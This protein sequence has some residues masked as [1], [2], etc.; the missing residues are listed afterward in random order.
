MKD[1]KIDMTKNKN[2]KGI[3]GVFHAVI[4]A[5]G[6]YAPECPDMS[7]SSNLQHFILLQSKFGDKKSQVKQIPSL[8]VRVAL[9]IILMSTY[10]LQMDS[11]K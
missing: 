9:S 10:V 1:K 7:N 5:E 8:I 2:V 6:H 4:R 3:D 11:L